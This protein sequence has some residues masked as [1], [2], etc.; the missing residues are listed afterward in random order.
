[1]AESDVEIIIQRAHE[2]Y[3]EAKLRVISDNAPQFMARDF[4]VLS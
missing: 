2:K 1:M 3:P 4:R